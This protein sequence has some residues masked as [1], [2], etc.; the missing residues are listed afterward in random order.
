MKPNKT[1]PY[2][3]FNWGRLDDLFLA[4]SATATDVIIERIAKM[5]I[6][7]NYALEVHELHGPETGIS[8]D[9]RKLA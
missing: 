9:A 3:P 1:K 4:I 6:I 5:L 8:R 7:S 2:C